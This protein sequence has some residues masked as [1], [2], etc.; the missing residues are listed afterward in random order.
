MNKPKTI[1]CDID[2]TLIKHSGC[3]SKQIMNNNCE[4]INNTLTVIDTW[5]KLGYKIILTTGRKEGMRKKTEEMLTNF[6]I[7]YDL[8]IMGLGGGDRI[9]INDK[10]ENGVENTAYAINVVRNKGIKNYNFNTKFVTISEDQTEKIKNIQG[11]EELIDYNDKYII[12][13]I[14]MKQGQCLGLQYH[15]LKRKTLYIL[16]GKIKIYLGKNNNNLEEKVMINGDH[17]T[18]EQYTI[19]SIEAIEDSY[20]IQN[21]TNETWDV[22]KI[23]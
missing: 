14:F 3:S 5:D 10:K 17:I 18:I 20:Y 8:L 11:H 2:G 12:K 1:F 23:K 7:T 16:T 15:E 22:I 21:S 9:L 19:H 4:L 6:G 13:K